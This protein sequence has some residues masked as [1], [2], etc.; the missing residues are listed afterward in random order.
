MS[1]DLGTFTTPW[2]HR[3]VLDAVDDTWCLSVGMSDCHNIDLKTV[4][5]LLK[6]KQK[7]ANMIVI[8]LR[9]VRNF[10]NTPSSV[11]D[12]IKKRILKK[13]SNI[14]MLRLHF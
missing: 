9:P 14:F 12:F 6:T 7:L 4:K 5:A 11:M 8:Y 3:K 1:L 13:N 2:L 10:K